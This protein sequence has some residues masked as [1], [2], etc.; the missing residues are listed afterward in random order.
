MRKV[1][2]INGEAMNRKIDLNPDYIRAVH[3]LENKIKNPFDLIKLWSIFGPCIEN[4][5]D[6]E[7]IRR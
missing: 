2:T 7:N 6:I 5:P 3:L 4:R 1:Y